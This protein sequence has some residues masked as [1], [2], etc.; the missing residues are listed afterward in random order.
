M[1]DSVQSGTEN[2]HSERGVAETA[3]DECGQEQRTDSHR[4]S[5]LTRRDALLI[6]G[7]SRMDDT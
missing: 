1:F 6:P 7:S 2:G 4:S 5:I 3:E